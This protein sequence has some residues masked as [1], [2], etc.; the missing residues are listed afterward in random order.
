MAASFVA[1][2][3]E[4]RSACLNECP[5]SSPIYRSSCPHCCS[6]ASPRSTSMASTTPPLA[7]FCSRKYLRT[8]PRRAA[9]YCTVPPRTIARQQGSTA[10]TQHDS[11]SASQHHSTTAPQHRSTAATRRRCTHE[12]THMRAQPRPHARARARAHVRTQGCGGR[13]CRAAR[14]RFGAAIGR[15]RACTAANITGLDTVLS[16]HALG[17]CL[18][19]CPLTAHMSKQISKHMPGA[20]ALSTHP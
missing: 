16:A 19:T 12:C 2:P 4:C 5:N 18:S 6:T 11:T 8:A 1:C 14:C 20:Q 10:A 17:V 7:A 9:W 3:N 15:S 13:H